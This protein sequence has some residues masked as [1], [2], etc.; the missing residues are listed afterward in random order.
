[1]TLDKAVLKQKLLEKC[2]ARLDRGLAAVEDARRIAGLP[3]CKERLRQMVEAEGAA[4]AQAR[5]SGKLKASW[6]AAEAVVEDSQAKR[7]YASVDWVM[8]PMVKPDAGNLP[9]R[10]DEGGF[11]LRNHGPTVAKE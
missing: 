9:V 5:G 11:N 3:I 6:T 1:M 7:V 8:A 4:V 2:E 10:F